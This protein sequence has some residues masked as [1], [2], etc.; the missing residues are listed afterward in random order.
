MSL[1]HETICLG[2]SVNVIHIYVEINLHFEDAGAS[3]H[4]DCRCSDIVSG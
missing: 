3:D 4:K 2:L 1:I